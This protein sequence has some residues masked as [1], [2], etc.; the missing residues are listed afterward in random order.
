[1]QH[2]TGDHHA[3]QVDDAAMPL[4]HHAAGG[5][6]AAE[7]C[8]LEVCVQHGIKI[9]LRHAQEQAVR[10]YYIINLLDVFVYNCCDHDGNFAKNNVSKGEKDVSKRFI[11]TDK[12]KYSD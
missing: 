6:L 9:G 12:R 11:R 8:A 2:F 4:A 7:E 5:L 10:K 3:G 1:M